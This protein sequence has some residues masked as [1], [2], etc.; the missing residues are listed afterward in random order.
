MKGMRKEW[1]LVTTYIFEIQRQTFPSGDSSHCDD[2]SAQNAHAVQPHTYVGS[3]SHRLSNI[4][5][6]QIYALPQS[7]LNRS[8]GL[9]LSGKEASHGPE[10]SSKIDFKH[11]IALIFLGETIV[12]QQPPI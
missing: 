1:D 6:V 8:S 3:K 4:T 2:K 5:L 9:T 11:S 10:E 7:N 12:S